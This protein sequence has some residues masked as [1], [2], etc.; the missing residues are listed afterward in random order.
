MSKDKLYLLVQH[1]S[2]SEK[3]Y[4]KLFLK[5]YSKHN[6]TSLYAQLCDFLV[7]SK[8]YDKEETLRNNPSIN[9]NQL[10]NIKNRLYNYILLSLRTYNSNTTVSTK[11]KLHEAMIDNEILMSKGLFLQAWN[12]LIKAEKVANKQEIHHMLLD[13]LDKQKHLI[14]TRLKSKK[15]KKHL[16]KIQRKQTNVFTLVTYINTFKEIHYELY[17]AFKFHGRIFR[18]TKIVNE[19]C[20]KL[21]EYKKHIADFETSYEASHLFY[22]N[23]YLIY[24]SIGEYTKSLD[25]CE[26]ILKKF[27]T[28]YVFN[29]DKFIKYRSFYSSKIISLN[30][31]GRHKEAR[32]VIN[33]IREMHKTKPTNKEIDLILFEDTF[34]FELE[35]YIMGFQ[36]DRAVCHI[37]SNQKNIDLFDKKM[38]SV[39]QQSKR[40]RIALSYFG[41][42]KF[43]EALIWINKIIK[44]DELK[45][46]KDILSSVQL[47]NLLIHFELGNYSLIKNKIEFVSTYLNKID[48]LLYPERLMLETLSKIKL[49]GKNKRD[50][51]LE[52]KFHLKVH[53]KTN[54]L[55]SYFFCYFDL[56]K[57]L[58]LQI[59]KLN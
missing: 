20:E 52:L 57:W 47:L 27:H 35:S 46:R 5:R 15:F 10:N 54:H 28:P 17:E 51:F 21:D 18:D 58:D 1:L 26:F 40:Y 23:Y 30:M 29:V 42:N 33:T 11:V 32:T 25:L 8:K 50:L 24:R 36:F 45:Y 22:Y 31:L 4:F 49:S 34:F 55:D 38:H 19:V 6:D 3:R 14:N 2:P 59:T 12:T 53:F 16:I 37:E 39:N 7:K 44:L 41:A 48:R 13:I 43:K 9:K 56:V